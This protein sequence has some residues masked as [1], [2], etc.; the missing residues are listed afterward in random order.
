MM[1]STEDLC[2]LRNLSRK[3]D[4]EL[5]IKNISTCIMGYSFDICNMCDSANINYHT[6][7]IGI[8][9]RFLNVSSFD[10][11]AFVCFASSASQAG[12]ADSSRAPGLTPGLQV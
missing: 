7:L 12:D 2:I 9:F 8:I 1:C 4:Q 3:I 11:T 6:L 5:K 10:N